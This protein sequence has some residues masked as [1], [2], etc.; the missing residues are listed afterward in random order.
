[1]G[2]ALAAGLTLLI[3]GGCAATQYEPETVDTARD[4]L[5]PITPAMATTQEFVDGYKAV[6][7]GNFAAAEPL[8]ARSLELEPNDP[9]ALL[10]MGAVMERT[11]RIY[12][13]TTYYNS[14]IRYGTVSPLGEI[15]SIDGSPLPEADTVSDV[16]RVNLTRIDGS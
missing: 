12:E 10:A 7:A 6:E 14:A 11:G 2:R 4:R 1:M 5:P 3:L 9:Y 13:A 15:K 16:A 8:L